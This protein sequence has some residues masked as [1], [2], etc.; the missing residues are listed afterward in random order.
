[1]IKAVF[2]DL[3]DT[4]L[5]DQKSVKK[6]FTATCEYAKE[7]D[8]RIDVEELEESVREEAKKLYASY[9]TYPFT[10][11]IGINPFE[12]LWANF[13]DREEDFQKLKELAPGYRNASWE[14]GLKKIGVENATLAKELS[15]RFP[16]ERRKNPIVY[17]ET[18]EVLDD[19]KEK[20]Q[21]LLIT[22]GS[23]DLQNIKLE[24]TPELVPYFDHIVISGA[25]GVGK[26]DKG[27][28]EHAL[29]LM[30]L[31]K[32]EAVMVG[33]NLMTD[34]LGAERAGISSIWVNRNEQSTNDVQ[35]TY[36]IK[37]LTEIVEILKT[38]S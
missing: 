6:A 22:N 19:L 17:E 12:G 31:E 14:L 16:L 28:F 8:N 9:E 18:F 26:P 37:N 23:P 33:D 36:E 7:Q 3:D 2:F 11:L 32:D 38:L 13:Q 30:E 21:L 10:K 24:L 15:E 34:I 27:I 4:L 5:W 20:Y 25:Y 29:S 35:P 1:M